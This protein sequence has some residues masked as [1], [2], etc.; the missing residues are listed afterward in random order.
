MENLLVECGEEMQR[1]EW[2]I[3]S[4]RDR[5]HCSRCSSFSR[6]SLFHIENT[7]ALNVYNSHSSIFDF[8]KCYSFALIAKTKSFTIHT[9][10]R[11]HFREER[12]LNSV[13]DSGYSEWA[14]RVTRRVNSSAGRSFS[15]RV[16]LFSDGRDG[17]AL[18]GAA[19]AVAICSHTECEWY[20]L[21]NEIRN[22]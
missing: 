19:A 12:D 17:A 4:K 15:L 7:L 13:C 1:K 14:V 2:I 16:A 9:F 20:I 8:T 11:H 18:E 22:N 5:P 10:W 21:Y 6:F 3:I